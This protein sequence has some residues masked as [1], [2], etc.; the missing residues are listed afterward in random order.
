MACIITEA[1]AVE[2]PIF[3]AL[4]RI[5]PRFRRPRCCW[6]C[7][8]PAVLHTVAYLSMAFFCIPTNYASNLY[9]R[10]A[11]RLSASKNRILKESTM[12]LLK[13]VQLCRISILWIIKLLFRIRFV[14][15]EKFRFKIEIDFYRPSSR[16]VSFSLARASRYISFSLGR[17]RRYSSSLSRRFPF[18]K[19][20]TRPCR[21]RFS[22]RVFFFLIYFRSI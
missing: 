7:F 2:S 8:P 6:P 9:L 13:R 19:T 3:V 22:R 20:C 17:G 14:G 16:S 21:L 4:S 15:L 11:V 10:N 5:V 18:K 1:A 12:K